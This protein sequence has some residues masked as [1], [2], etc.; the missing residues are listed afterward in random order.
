MARRPAQTAV[1]TQIA[2]ALRE[3]IL[4]GEFGQDPL[5]TQHDL[6]KEYG[7]ARQTVREATNLLIS[8]GLVETGRGRGMFV[9]QV[10]H[11]I[12][13]P[14]VE[15]GRQP[16]DVMDRWMS[17]LTEEGRQPS[18]TI[19][20]AVVSPPLDVAQRLRIPADAP[21]V[22]RRRVRSIDGIAYYVNDSYY[23]LDLVAGSAIMLPGDIAPGAN[24]LLTELGAHQVRAI[25][26]FHL[27]MPR[28]DEVAR[29]GLARGVP[30][31][32]Q[33]TTGITDDDRPVRCVIS[34][35]P[36]DRCIVMYERTRPAI[37][38]PSGDGE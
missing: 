1:Y 10:R 23:P 36:G 38:E 31:A 29:L 11:M 19:D 22:V 20:V 28:P 12:Y 15:F 13:R 5:P 35:L 34:V 6:A 16:S 4:K 30:V 2:D 26:E 18:Q 8:E 7:V 14:Q 25:D 32:V 33:I 9:R 27:R 21:V 37:A 17:E 24:D 3:R